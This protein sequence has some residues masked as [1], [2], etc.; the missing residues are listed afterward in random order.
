MT[1]YRSAIRR[2]WPVCGLALVLAT[3]GACAKNDKLPPDPG[4]ADQFL[5][6]RGQEAMAKKHWLDAREY[7][8]QIVENYSGS[9]LRSQ[10][11]LSI[12]DSYLQEGTADALVSAATEYREFL[13]FY[14]TD[15]RADQAQYNLAMTYFKQMRK[16]ERDQT[17]THETLDEF[18]IFFQQYPNSALMG[19]ARK[20]WRIARD[21]LSAAG[22]GVGVTYMK[23]KWF[24]GAIAR[25]NEVILTDP[26]YTNMDAVYFHLA[27]TLARADRKQ[28]AI[29][30]FDRVVREYPMSEYL[31]KAQKRL[32]ELNAR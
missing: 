15:A 32:K 13:R 28:E 1:K 19:D 30:L 4:V 17:A 21:R 27:E 23:Q 18:G 16:P 5:M 29:P 20:N 31:P 12:G 2:V 8:R 9:P 10:A 7:F 11:K 3:A 24:P 26:E 22:F 25:F 6:Q 14:P